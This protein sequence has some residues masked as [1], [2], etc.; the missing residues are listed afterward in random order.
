MRIDDSRNGGDPLPH[1]L[2]HPQIICAIT[3]DDAKV[4]LRRQSEIENLRGHVGG[5]EIER[6][7]WEGGWQHLSKS[8]HIIGRRGMSLLERYQDR[9]VVDVDGRAI[10]ESK[11]V[12]PL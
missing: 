5:L 8:A 6:H 4:D 11:V 10:R 9:A 3:A 12:H 7:R 2:R 1:L